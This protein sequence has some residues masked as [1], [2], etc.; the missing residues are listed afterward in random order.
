MQMANKRVKKYSA[1][2]TISDVYHSHS[3]T[4]PH[5]R[6]DVCFKTREN[7]KRWAGYVEIGTLVHSWWERKTVYPLWKTVAVSQK[8]KNRVTVWL[9]N[10]ASE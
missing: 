1:S 7:N 8:I 3:E 6:Q 4:P 9:K 5:A 10:S 2:L